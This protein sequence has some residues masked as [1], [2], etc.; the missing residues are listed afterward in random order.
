MG[1]YVYVCDKIKIKSGYITR[2]YFINKGTEFEI[3]FVD[4]GTNTPYR[5]RCLTL[6]VTLWLK[7]DQ[8]NVVM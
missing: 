7:R 4:K 3:T 5:C 1:E 6:P 8:F 2:E